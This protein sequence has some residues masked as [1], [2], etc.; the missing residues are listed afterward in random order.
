MRKI[1]NKKFKKKK[2]HHLHLLWLKVPN[3][4]GFGP[5][6]CLRILEIS[7]LNVRT[8]SFIYYAQ[9]KWTKFCSLI[10]W[11]SWW[12]PQAILRT[13]SEYEVTLVLL[14]WL[15]VYSEAWRCNVDQWLIDFWGTNIHMCH[16]FI[17]WSLHF[18]QKARA[19]FLWLQYV[20]EMKYIY[21]GTGS[22]G[23]FQVKF[24]TFLWDEVTGSM[25]WEGFRSTQ[26]YVQIEI[27]GKGKIQWEQTVS[28][29]RRDVEGC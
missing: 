11:G 29:M 15:L 23:Y 21:S 12:E 22:C 16:R 14:A 3:I 20:W 6:N 13:G 28:K 27:P 2:H 9:I 24:T 5:L 1:P 25:W 26:I 10:I 17:Y 8:I 18:M 7:Y 4:K 19:Y